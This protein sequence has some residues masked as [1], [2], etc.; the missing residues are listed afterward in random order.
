MREMGLRRREDL[1]PRIWSAKRGS[2]SGAGSKAQSVRWLHLQM[3]R[4]GGFYVHPRCKR[5]IESIKGWDYTDASEWKDAIDAL[6]YALIP[7]WRG[8]RRRRGAGP[9]VVVG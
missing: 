1:R 7:W 2:D 9:T 4:T 3:L 8:T 5:L 6:R